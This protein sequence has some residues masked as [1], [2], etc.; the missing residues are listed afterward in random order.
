MDGDLGGPGEL[1][2]GKKD[3]ELGAWSAT[4][5]TTAMLAY[6]N[7]C[8]FVY[9]EEDCLAFGP[10]VKQLYTDL[11]DGGIAFGYKQL[12]DPYMPATGALFIVRRNFIPTFVSS[13]IEVGDDRDFNRL[14]E[15]RFCSIEEKF[16]GAIARRLSFGVDRERPIPWDNPVWYAQQISLE[17]LEEFRRRNLVSN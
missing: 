11:G 9:V 15:H 6:V 10:W 4:M 17:E 8:D 13:Y 16:G 3:N 12:T 1:I 2:H 7:E 5:L 14:P